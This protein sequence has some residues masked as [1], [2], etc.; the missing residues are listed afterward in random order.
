MRTQS[1]GEYEHT[2]HSVKPEVVLLYKDNFSFPSK[3]CLAKMRRAACEMIAAAHRA[4]ARVIAAGS[5]VSDATEPYLR[6]RERVWTANGERSW[7]ASRGVCRGAGN[8]ARE[9]LADGWLVRVLPEWTEETY[10]LDAYHHSA[11]LMSAKVRAFL[12][13]VVALTR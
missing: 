13:F 3:M 4:D 8:R 12:D 1:L 10:P 2:L 11:Q 7:F 6:P 9:L 5:N